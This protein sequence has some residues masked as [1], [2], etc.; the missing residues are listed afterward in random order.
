MKAEI[1][2]HLLALYCFANLITLL[3]AEWVAIYEDFWDKH[4]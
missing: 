4:L 3:S 2:R 1:L